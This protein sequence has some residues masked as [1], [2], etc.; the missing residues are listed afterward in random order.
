[1]GTNQS[2]TPKNGL[3]G[4]AKF[5]HTMNEE[6]VQYLDKWKKRYKFKGG[7]YTEDCKQLCEEILKTCKGDEKRERKEGLPQA[8]LWLEQ[9]KKR[10]EC[11][12]KKKLLAMSQV[13]QQDDDGTNAVASSVVLRS[14]VVTQVQD[15]APIPDLTPS[16]PLATQPLSLPPYRE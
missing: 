5:M 13:K 1:M 4:D 14:V 15:P 7:L 6:S 12:R 9:V 10:S 3:T 16:S 11:R 8:H 2:K